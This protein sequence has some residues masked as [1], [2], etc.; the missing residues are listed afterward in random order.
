MVL[1]GHCVRNSG[2]RW[3]LDGMPGAPTR[4]L[5]MQR[6]CLIGSRSRIAAIADMNPE[7]AGDAGPRRPGQLWHGALSNVSTKPRDEVT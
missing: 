1:A 3:L 5:A 4:R 2:Q 7:E 6:V